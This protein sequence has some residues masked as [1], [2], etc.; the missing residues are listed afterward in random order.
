MLKMN[1]QGSRFPPGLRTASEEAP[2]GDRRP[3]GDPRGVG[4]QAQ[5]PRGREPLRT[6]RET[7]AVPP[8]PRTSRGRDLVCTPATARD[9]EGKAQRQEPEGGKRDRGRAE[10]GASWSGPRLCAQGLRSPAIP[11]GGPDSTGRGRRPVQSVPVGREADSRSTR[12][13]SSPSHNAKGKKTGR[14]ITLREPRLEP[15]G[16][17]SQETFQWQF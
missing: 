15:P 13:P 3:G 12:G 2:S 9:G 11:A 14:W 5:E 16:E 10:G 1:M 8:A 17:R 6:G 4:G 7:G